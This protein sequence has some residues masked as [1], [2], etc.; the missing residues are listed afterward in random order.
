MRGSALF[1]MFGVCSGTF[2]IHFVPNVLVSSLH[3][4][5]FEHQAMGYQFAY[6]PQFA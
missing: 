1:A 6:L 3:L 5:R 2:G 4:G